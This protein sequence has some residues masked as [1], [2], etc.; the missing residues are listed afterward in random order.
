VLFLLRLAS[1]C[2]QIAA[3]RSLW[4]RWRTRP[5]PSKCQFVN[6]CQFTWCSLLL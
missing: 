4:G 2:F 3:C 5:S 6:V 1:N